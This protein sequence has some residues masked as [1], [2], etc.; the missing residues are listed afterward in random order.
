MMA[1][2]EVPAAAGPGIYIWGIAMAE[3][4]EFVSSKQ[5]QKEVPTGISLKAI[6]PLGT[7]FEWRAGSLLL[8]SKHLYFIWKDQNCPILSL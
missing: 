3:T 4:E 2:A 7:E 5:Q 6:I 1:E 8:L